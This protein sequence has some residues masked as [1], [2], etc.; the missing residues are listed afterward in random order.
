MSWASLGPST[1]PG[2]VAQRFAMKSWTIR[3][4]RVAV[5]QKRRRDLGGR[6]GKEEVDEDNELLGERALPI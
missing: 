6:G 4:G 2:T 5:K 1:G 3:R